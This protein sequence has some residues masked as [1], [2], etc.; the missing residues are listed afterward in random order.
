[1]N[2]SI[3]RVLAMKKTIVKSKQTIVNA[4]SYPINVTVDYAWIIAEIIKRN[5][6]IPEN[7][8]EVLR[9]MDREQLKDASNEK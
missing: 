2:V 9:Q 3:R 4:S 8:E 1:M 6:S 5:G 7:I